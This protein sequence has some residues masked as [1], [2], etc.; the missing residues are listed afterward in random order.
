MARWQWSPFGRRRAGPVLAALVVVVVA[1]YLFHLSGGVAGEFRGHAGEFLVADESMPDGRFRQ[2]VILMIRHDQDGA[3]GVI[4]NK[5]LAVDA[6]IPLWA[7][8]GDLDDKGAEY[9]KEVAL[10]FGGPVDRRRLFV[11]HDAGYASEGTI[12]LL[13]GL[14]ATLT[15]APVHDIAKGEGP[16]RMLLTLGY[17]GWGPGQLEF[18]IARG[19]WHWVAADA[20]VVF[21]G[22][23][24]EKWT[25]AYA[26][27][28][29]DL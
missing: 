15:L 5:P 4:V 21:G 27:R 1:A 24:A 10:Y 20:E 23:D 3:L 11:V 26:R 25:R 2:S 13:G 16:A 19:S 17:A 29:I 28:G 7:L 8:V 22:A 9:R 6:T 18:E 12:P 14:A